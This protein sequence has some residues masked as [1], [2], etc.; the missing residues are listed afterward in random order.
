M[1]MRREIR[2]RLDSQVLFLWASV[3]HKRLQG[4]GMTR[5]LSV[6]GAFI[7]TATCPPVQT[8]IQLEIILPS[9]TEMRTAIRIK[10]MA[11]VVRV[12]HSLTGVGQNGFAV[13][14]DARHEWNLSASPGESD[15]S[16]PVE[17]IEAGA[18]VR[19]QHQ[20][21]SSHTPGSISAAR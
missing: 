11:R 3:D 2:Y 9:L 20:Y 18:T 7:H 19:E 4:D 13:V 17:L 1:E 14:R 16:R 10:G 8:A 12:E 15:A 5:D 21:S 6:F